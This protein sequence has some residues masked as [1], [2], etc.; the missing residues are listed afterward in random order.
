MM[1][2]MHFLGIYNVN[3]TVVYSLIV[4]ISHQ[5]CAVKKLLT[6]KSTKYVYI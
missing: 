3:G 1:L 6:H 5:Q 4:L 2:L